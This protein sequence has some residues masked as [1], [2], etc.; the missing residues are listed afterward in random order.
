MLAGLCVLLAA[1]ILGFI[2]VLSSSNNANNSAQINAVSSTATANAL[3][4]TPTLP[5][6]TP[7]VDPSATATPLPAQQYIDSA[8]MAAGV[9]QSPISAQN[10]TTTFKSGDSMY[11][12]FDVHPPS[13]GGFVCSEWYLNDT[14]ITGADNALP[15]KGSSHT[16]YIYAQFGS[17]STGTGYVNLYWA[18]DQSCTGQQLAQHVTFT[19]TA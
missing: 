15:V 5:P 11:V 3:Q 10:P 12:V 7:T 9:N 17:G 8:Q 14:H 1:L 16:T 2:A 4:V 6:A 13:S 19:L 18:N